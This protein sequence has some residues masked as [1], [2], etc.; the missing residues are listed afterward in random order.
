M[1]LPR[2]AFKLALSQGRPQIGLWCS[3][4][5]HISV[6]VVAGSGFDWLVLDM[7]HSANDVPMVLSQLQAANGGTAMPVVRPPWNDPVVTKRLLDIGV[8]SF[9]FPFVQNAEEARLAVASTRYPPHGI[10]G[11]ATTTRANRFGR[12][13]DYH[14]RAHEEICVLVQVETRTAISNL[15]AILAVE[16]VDGVFIGPSDLSADLGHLGNSRHP[17]VRA[18]IADTIRRIRAAGKAPGF[19]SG[20][21]EDARAALDAGALFVAVGADVGILARQSEALRQKFPA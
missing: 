6:E 9:L 7:E 15:D 16:G 3:L 14:Q 8:Q 5:S 11:V 18:L 1:D 12:V 4:A 10:R 19:L 17:D 13:K 2:N 20:V 21:E